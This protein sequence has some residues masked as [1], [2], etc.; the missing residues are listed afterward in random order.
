MYYFKGKL[1]FE[2]W[3]TNVRLKEVA[4]PRSVET[5]SDR[6]FAPL[7]NNGDAEGRGPPE[8]TAFL[9]ALQSVEL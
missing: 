2:V 7:P 5:R 4:A 1:V 8:R 3:V 9:R 6:S